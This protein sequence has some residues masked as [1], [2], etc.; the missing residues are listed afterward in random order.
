MSGWK[1]DY[2]EWAGTLGDK[3]KGKMKRDPVDPW[4]TP[5]LDDFSLSEA[6][7]AELDEN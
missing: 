7:A 4:M 6:A 1:F 5:C 2:R 3:M